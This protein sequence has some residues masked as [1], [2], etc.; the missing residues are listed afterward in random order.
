[1]IDQFESWQTNH[2][3]ELT[4]PIAERD[5]NYYEP[6]SSGDCRDYSPLESTDWTA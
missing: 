3:A 2:A 4:R 1:M 5:I 6:V